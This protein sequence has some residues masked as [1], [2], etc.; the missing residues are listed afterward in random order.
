MTGKLGEA[1]VDTTCILVDARLLAR[2]Q[3]FHHEPFR[4][5][6][7]PGVTRLLD[8]GRGVV[9]D[10]KNVL[11]RDGKPDAVTLWRL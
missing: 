11:T 6:G 3:R 8:A 1:L 7:W 9:A 10:I 5:M 2:S 4:K